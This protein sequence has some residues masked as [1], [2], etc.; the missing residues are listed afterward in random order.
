MIWDDVRDGRAAPDVFRW[1]GSADRDL[2]AEA[3]AAGW[4]VW[5]LDT[6]SVGT[7]EDFYGEVRAAWGL[8]PWFGDNLDAL[9]DALRDAVQTPAV[10]IWDGSRAVEHID[11]AWAD[12]VLT[13][14]RDTVEE[15]SAFA[16]VL[17]G[18]AMTSDAVPLS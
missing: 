17:R 11:R 8:P 9:F 15:S 3:A 7:V 4:T 14:L 6:S 5:S 16:V 1:A 2:E 12:E 18:D 13:V 10:L